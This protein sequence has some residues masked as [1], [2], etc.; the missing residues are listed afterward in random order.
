M[1]KEYVQP[2]VS[3]LKLNYRIKN[4]ILRNSKLKFDDSSL[5]FA[6]LPFSIE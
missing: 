5:I 2:F 1:V 4:L 6:A 3:S